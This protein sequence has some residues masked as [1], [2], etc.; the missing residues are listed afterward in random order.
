MTDRHPLTESD[1]QP[2]APCRPKCYNVTTAVSTRVDPKVREQIFLFINYSLVSVEHIIDK[3][4]IPY[5]KF[6]YTCLAIV[7]KTL[8][9]QIALLPEGNMYIL[10]N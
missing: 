1:A 5:F 10:I 3:T 7:L 6:D 4:Y 9:G 2:T 8:I